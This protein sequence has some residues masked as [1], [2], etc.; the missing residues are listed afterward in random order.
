MKRLI[1]PFALIIA[2]IFSCGR[3]STVNTK[4]GMETSVKSVPLP[5]ASKP[6]SALYGTYRGVLPCK[7][8]QS[9]QIKLTFNF[10]DTYEIEE[11]RQNK[12]SDI[13]KHIGP[14]KYY[15]DSKVIKVP[16]P[17]EDLMFEAGENIL[18]FLDEEGNRLQTQV[19][20]TPY[21]FK[22]EL[23]LNLA[24]WQ[25]EKVGNYVVPEELKNNSF[26]RFTADGGISYSGGCNICRCSYFGAS[27]GSIVIKNGGICTKKY[28][29]THFDDSLSIYLPQ[30]NKYEIKDQ[31]L[32]L[33]NKGEHTILLRSAF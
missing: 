17:D 23:S 10:D 30:S 3:P 28:C 16:L 21:L 24:I 33:S 13:I 19:S 9:R 5:R 14:F 18:Y 27:Q 25:I 31:M 22:T 26:L 32:Q 11:I 1:I 2:F 12:M 29:E 20:E 4:E 8:C 6:D 7:G 15:G